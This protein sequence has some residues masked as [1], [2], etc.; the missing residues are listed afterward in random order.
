[1]SALAGIKILEL[2]E[3]VS[4]EYCGK[5]LADFGA[6]VIKIEKPASGSPTRRIG[7]FAGGV[8]SNENSGLFAYLNTGKNSI[9]LDLT[10]DTGRITLGKL[11]NQVAVVIDDHSAAWLQNLGL[12]ADSAQR[13]HPGLVICSITNYGLEPPEDRIHS[14]DLNVFHSSGWGYHTP[15]GADPA[16]PPLK[17][18]GRFLPSY[19]A[20]IEAAVCINAALFERMQSG[21]GSFI[22]ISKQ[23]VMASRIDY[24]LAQ[25]VAGDMNVSTDRGAFDLAG[26]AGIFPCRDGYVYIWLSAPAHWEGLRKLLTDTAWM[27]EFPANW[28]ERGC[29]PERVTLCRQHIT[30]WL[31]TQDKH[32]AA[33]KAQTLGVTLV[34]VNNAED[35]VASPQY[36]FRNFFV[37]LQHPV[38][39]QSLYPTV[40]YQLSATPARPQA[41]AP[42]LGQHNDKLAT[43]TS[44]K[45]E[46]Q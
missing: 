34:A 46:S 6:E 18:A 4:G 1:M 2:A 24:V 26:P 16:Q 27:E 12:D 32:D 14:E 41:A 11:L 29:T 43:V 8:E 31:K 15:T 30:A 42:L 9:E 22:E 40:P 33:A 35:L 23:D 7:P 10:S 39:G 17:G 21:L 36:Q 5:L 20:G 45:G 3:T 25:M 37:E 28:L 19:E 38:L 13:A 44:A